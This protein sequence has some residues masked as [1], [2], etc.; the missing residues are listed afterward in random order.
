VRLHDGECERAPG[1]S[2]G[3]ARLLQAAALASLPNGIEPMDKAIFA[4]LGRDG[5]VPGGWVAGPRQ[6][7]RD[8]RPY[9]S[10]WWGDGDGRARVLVKGA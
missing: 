7:V 10:H 1:E 3:S 9:V 5:A 2:E 6:G 4:A 8:G